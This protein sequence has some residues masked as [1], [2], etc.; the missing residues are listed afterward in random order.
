[1]KTQPAYLVLHR[2]RGNGKVMISRVTQRPPYLEPGEAV[3]KV[4]LEIPDTILNH[5]VNVIEILPDDIAVAVEIED[6][7][8]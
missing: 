3:V 4:A 5:P 8:A 2:H 1:M 7:Q 6:P